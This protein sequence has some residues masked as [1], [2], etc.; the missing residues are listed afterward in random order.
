MVSAY[1]T[2]QTG[3]VGTYNL[4]VAASIDTGV[5]PCPAY[6]FPRKAWLFHIENPP[7]ALPKAETKRKQR[8]ATW[9]TLRRAA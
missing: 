3:Q 4:S 2:P 7:K 6:P 9:N 1:T 5:N 8:S